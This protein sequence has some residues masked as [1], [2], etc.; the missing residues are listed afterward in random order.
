MRATEKDFTETGLRVEG[1]YEN[2]RNAESAQCFKD[3]IREVFGVA[4]KLWG[5]DFKLVL[6]RLACEPMETRDKLF[7]ELYYG[8]KK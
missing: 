6:T 2:D 4:Q 7:A 8:R 3:V 1:P 5:E